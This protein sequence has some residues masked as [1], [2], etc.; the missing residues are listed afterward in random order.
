MLVTNYKV[1]FLNERKKTIL[2]SWVSGY[3]Y[4]LTKIHFSIF[5][6]I[7]LNCFDYCGF[8]VDIAW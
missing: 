4:I 8:L 3:N 7:G 5:M 2:V 6:S 1:F